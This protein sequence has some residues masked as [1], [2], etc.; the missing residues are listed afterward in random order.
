MNTSL[1]FVR[2]GTPDDCFDHRPGR[3]V[4][5]VFGV[6]VLLAVGML[7]ASEPG[8]RVDVPGEPAA[9]GD[10]LSFLVQATGGED[11]LWG[12]LKVAEDEDWALVEAPVPVENSVSPSWELTLVPLKT[13]TIALPG[14]SAGWRPPDGEVQ[15]IEVEKGPEITV[16]S[17]IPPDGDTEPAALKPPARVM[18]F[19]WEWVLPILVVIL[20][21][22][23]LGFLLWRIRSKKREHAAGKQVL[24]P[25][26]E[27]RRALVETESALGKIPPEGVCDRL[28]FILRRYLERRSDHPAGEMTS[29]ELRNLARELKWPAV[30]QTDLQKIMPLMDRVRFARRPTTEAELR[31]AI[32]TARGLARRLE[33]HY[34]PGDE[35]SGS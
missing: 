14:I 35:R 2:S 23:F 27:F 16:A 25:Y 19:P 32:D 12:Q 4:P 8:L 31:Q 21:V 6:L 3:M 30:V 5:L 7:S 1:P 9:V 24:P 13:G 33:E 34:M 20:P 18:G 15:T 22:L 10:R 28:A 17:V 11:G 29:S 26:E